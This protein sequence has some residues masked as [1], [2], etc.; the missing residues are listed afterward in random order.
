MARNGKLPVFVVVQLTGGNDFMN[1][2]VPYASPA[3]Y[4][5][6]PTVKISQNDVLPVN[7]QLG[8]NPNLAP[9]KEMYDDGKV[10]VVQGIGYPN[11]SRS[12]FRAMDIWHTCEPNKVGKEGWL[13]WAIRELDP[14]K[15]NVLTGVNLGKGMPRALVAPGVPITSVGDLDN[16]GLMTGIAE[17][18]RRDRA[19][20]MFKEM[21]APAI[22]TGP[23]M[24]YLSQIGTD[25]LSGADILKQAPA[26]YSSEVEYADNAIAKNLRDVARVHLAGLGTRIFYA[27]HGGYD[28]HAN[29][30]KSHPKLLD[31]LSR[32]IMDFFHDLR[33]H[34]GSDEVVMLVF[35]EFGRRMRDNG[36][37]TD[38]GSGG[39]AFIIGDHVNGGL[40]SEYP[41][42]NPDQWLN[43]EDLRHT[44]DFR[45]V[46]ATLLEQW[47][48]LDPVP[49]VDGTFEQIHPFN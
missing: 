25:V 8:F 43:G 14:K 12:H 15:E 29:E 9:I 3:Y 22:G 21:Y 26:M 28:H 39:G 11:S 47:L 20:E 6:R 37:G 38:H 7:E 10:A 35:T 23:V 2:L 49:I 30:N 32:A 5:A 46:Y 45:G 16:Y 40:Y 34:N 31:E 24:D 18:H 4:D 41:P 33:A 13:G 42:M 36:S 1:T 17:Q 19:L 44:V 48:D 27:N